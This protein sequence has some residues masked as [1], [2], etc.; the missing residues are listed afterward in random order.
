MLEHNKAKELITAPSH[1]LKSNIY[2]SVF[3]T[4]IQDFVSGFY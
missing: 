2:L 4:T 1:L 3:E